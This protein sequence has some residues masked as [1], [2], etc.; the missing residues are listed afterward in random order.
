MR[1]L[2]DEQLP[3]LLADVLRSK[4]L[5]AIHVSSLLIGE[6]IPDSFIIHTS[7]TQNW[8]VITKDIDFLNSYILKNTPSKLIYVTTG[9]I[10]NRELLDLFR[11]VIGTLANYLEQHDVIE[12]NRLAIHV[13][14]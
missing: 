5:E 6:R 4:G 7:V 14:Y 1:F 10:K 12:I 3:H 9:N 13:L 11:R 2:I 8:V